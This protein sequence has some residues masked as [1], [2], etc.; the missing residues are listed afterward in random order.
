[1]NKPDTSKQIIFWWEK[2]RLNFS[3]LFFTLSFVCYLI[4]G[5]VFGNNI[6]LDMPMWV[7]LELGIFANIL[8]TF[9]WI[10]EIFFKKINKAF[11]Q[12]FRL[13]FYRSILFLLS[14]L[15]IGTAVIIIILETW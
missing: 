9:T 7:I 2:R 6:E 11:S 13:Y 12:S 1:M 5:K 15:I 10:I 3:L 8:Y 4:V 14:L